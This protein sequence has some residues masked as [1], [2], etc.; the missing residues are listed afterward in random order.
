MLNILIQFK[1]HPH[2]EENSGHT[3]MEASPTAFGRLAP[4]VGV[5]HE[6]SGCV[7]C[8]HAPCG[9]VYDALSELV[10]RRL[11]EMETRLTARIELAAADLRE[12][13]L[14]ACSASASAA[15]VRASGCQCVAAGARNHHCGSVSVESE[16]GAPEADGGSSSGRHKTSNAIIPK[17]Q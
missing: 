15:A 9:Q 8:A 2:A 11:A 13:L 4:V 14:N 10:D 6:G 1:F 7:G 5:P 3:N 16:E 17:C 12:A